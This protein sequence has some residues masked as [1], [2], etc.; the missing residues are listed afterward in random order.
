MS[1]K[2]KKTI[3]WV[4]VVECDS[5]YSGDGFGTEVILAYEEASTSRE[6]AIQIAA[7]DAD[8]ICRLA[9]KLQVM[10]YLDESDDEED[11]PELSHSLEHMADEDKTYYASLFKALREFVLSEGDCIG[12]VLTDDNFENLVEVR[13]R[14]KY[15]DEE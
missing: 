13:V 4:E 5:D 2:T 1:E 15:F 11:V 8:W 10:G 6:K 7:E 12:E 14:S 3:Y 9:Y